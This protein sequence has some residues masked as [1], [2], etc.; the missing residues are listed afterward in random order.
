MSPRPGTATAAAQAEQGMLGALG[1]PRMTVGNNP[2]IQSQAG[3]RMDCK[4]TEIAL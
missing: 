1:M 3:T 4:V 2:F